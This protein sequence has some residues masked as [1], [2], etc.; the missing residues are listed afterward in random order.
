MSWM[1]QRISH[2]E[3]GAH[4]MLNQR[5]EDSSNA[6]AVM[7]KAGALFNVYYPPAGHALGAD[8]Y[9]AGVVPLVGSG[10]HEGHPL[11]KWVVRADTNETLGL[12]SGSYAQT[13]S[14]KYVGE[15]AE[16]LF[17][18]STESCTLFGKGERM[19]LA[20]NIGEPIDLGDGDIIKPQVMWVSSYNG[21][22]STAVYHLTHRWFCMNQLA[23]ASPIFSVKHTTNHNFTFEQ[24]S[25]IL[26]EAMEH[27]QVV[28][29]MART[30]KDQAFTDAQF[31]H[32]VKQVV[33]LPKPFNEVGDIHAIAETRMKK[34][35]DAMQ[36]VWRT[37]CTQFG[38]VYKIDQTTEAFDGNRWLAYN[39][40]QGAEQ[41]N[42][43]ARFNTSDVGKQRSM[44]KM[45]SGG[46]PFASRALDLLRVG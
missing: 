37:E 26:L 16:R 39:A 11:Y 15:M 27:A 18:N 9:G 40:V 17:P 12:H 32:L 5:D 42:I 22:W 36:L 6:L 43:N 28:A 10:K 45:I 3:P 46:T 31:E 41:H 7:E 8:P 20:Q 2:T 25:N 33:P 30:L 29:R 21:Q 34:N 14:Y 44:T 35:R 38:N 19:A 24:R 13:D 4:P 1:T 23:G